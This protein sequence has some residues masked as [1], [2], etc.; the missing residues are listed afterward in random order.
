V[1]E[2]LGPRAPALALDLGLAGLGAAEGGP[3]VADWLGG[4]GPWLARVFLADHDGRARSDL[5]PGVGLLP[6]AE[7]RELLADRGTPVLRGDPGL[8]ASFLRGA[9]RHLTAILGR[10][11][12]AGPRS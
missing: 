12:G 9:E 10:L 5:L 2:D 11:P 6:W 8:P 4:L 1:Q 7:L 3:A